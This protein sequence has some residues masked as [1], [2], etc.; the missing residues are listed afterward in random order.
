MPELLFAVCATG[1]TGRLVL[2][3]GDVEKNVFLSDGQV[4]F[5][6]SSSPDDRLGAYTLQRNSIVLCLVSTRPEACKGLRKKEKS[7]I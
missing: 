5:A 6:A 2:H 3:T 1:K 4:V 7:Q